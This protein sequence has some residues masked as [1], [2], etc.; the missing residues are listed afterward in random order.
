MTSGK[1]SEKFLKQSELITEDLGEGLSRQIM[2]YNDQIMMVKVM[3]EEGTVGYEHH[4]PH[5][6]TTYV[7]SGEFE[8]NI[9]G[10]KKLLKKGDGFFAPPDEPH[11]VVCKKAG[12]LIDVFS[13]VREDFL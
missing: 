11:G 1:I 10:E 6:Q 12:A 8:V 2:G 4:H 9:N 3:F 5:V 7:E 13:P